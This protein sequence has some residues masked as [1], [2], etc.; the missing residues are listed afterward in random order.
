MFVFCDAT[1]EFSATTA[2]AL[3]CPSSNVVGSNYLLP[4]TNTVI[5]NI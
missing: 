2:T 1:S 4:N 5:M 3:E